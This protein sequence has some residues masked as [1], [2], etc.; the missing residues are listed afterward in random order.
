VSAAAKAF[1]FLAE[2]EAYFA[3]LRV[4]FVRTRTS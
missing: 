4:E 1:H 2:R 3:S